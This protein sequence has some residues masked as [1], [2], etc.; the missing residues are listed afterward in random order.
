MTVATEK[1]RIIAILDTNSDIVSV[2]KG[3]LREINSTPAF[4]VIAGDS[5]RTLRGG[6][7]IITERN[8]SI[9]GCIKAV[10]EGREFDAEEELEAWYTTIGNLFDTRP[11]L[12]LTDY[13]DTLD[14]VQEAFLVSD[15]GFG[16]IEVAGTNYAGS[17]WILRVVSHKLV[18]RGG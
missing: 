1:A 15:S 3:S 9:F 11:G 18:T 12:W 5:T 17:E 6:D 14:G 4:F 16:V 13:S 2:L 10:E 7:Q 8:Y